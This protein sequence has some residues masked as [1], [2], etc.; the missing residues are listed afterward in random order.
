MTRIKDVIA[1]F[2]Q[3][4]P[5]SLAEKGDPVGLQLGD[6]NQPLKKMMVTLDVRP[7]V[8]E[9]AIQNKVDFIFA[10]H[11]AMFRPVKHFDLSV[12]Q[13]RMYAE[14]IKHDITVY[15]AHTNLD[16]VNGGMNDWLADLLQ[17]K[18]T[19]P[20]MPARYEKYYK[21][22]VFVPDEYAES[23]R[24]AL[25]QAGA[26]E[27]GDYTACSYSIQ[28]QGRFKPG[29]DAH[30][31]IGTQD[32]LEE[33]AEEKIEVVL[34]ASLKD[35]VL[36]AMLAAHPYEE[37]AY[38][39]YELEHVGQPY[40]MGRIGQLENP[41][42]VKEY[43]EFCKQALKIKHLRIVTDD[44]SRL[45]KRVAVL[46]G[47]GS[48]FFPAA[49]RKHAD[50]YVTADVTY[51]TGHDIIASGLS[52]I[53]PG[54]HFESICKPHLQKLFEKWNEENGWG[55]DVIQSQLNTDPFIYL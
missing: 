54:H 53:D 18:E 15:G 5:Q 37:P 13:N 45:V 28:G 35:H 47:S 19:S 38:D 41:M 39:L 33:T 21:L 36:E 22:A 1:R 55:I 6:V 34:P 50:V 42:T 23:M 3:F 46:G 32:K 7:E 9:E 31:F 49:V 44:T 10:H 26:G 4:A 40:G 51:H 2:E 12:P 16:N 20:L 48:H 27:L 14:L 30:P 8:V 29:K 43:A 24:Q 11:P 52:V 17:I 25:S